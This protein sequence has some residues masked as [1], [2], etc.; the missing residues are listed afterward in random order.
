MRIVL[1]TNILV[2]ANAK[3]KGPARRLLQLIVD[4]PE[5][6]LLLSPFLL[7][8]LERVFSYDRVR[9]S[10]RLSDE[11]VAEY[12][13]YLRAKEVSEM[14]FPGPAPSVVPSDSDDDPVVHTA[15]VG[16]ADVLCTLNRHF[17]HPAVLG[18]CKQRGVLVGTD[19]EVLNFFRGPRQSPK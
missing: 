16:R 11:E 4:S 3:A 1:D 19:V 14:V 6:V 18:Y 5:H 13:G 17:Y 8:E 10:T 2:R 9:I 12:L 15:V 7:M